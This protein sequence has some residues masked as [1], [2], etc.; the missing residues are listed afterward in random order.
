MEKYEKNKTLRLVTAGLL[1]ALQIVLSRVVAIEFTQYFRLGGAF[2][3]QAVNGALLGPWIAAASSALAD[4]I[5]YNLKPTGPYIYGFTFTAAM[6]GM[7]YGLFLYRKKITP[8]RIAKAVGLI[9]IINH[10]LLNSLWLTIW[11]NIPYK[12]QLMVRILPEIAMWAIQVLV[13]SLVL[14]RLVRHLR[15]M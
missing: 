12:K 2:L 14:P 5:G 1:I 9:T 10:Y 7:F 13:L 4:I 8:V 15:N 11:F 3:A 6:T